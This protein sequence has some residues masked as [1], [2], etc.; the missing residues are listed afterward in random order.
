MN[1]FCYLL[2]H[3][4]S[5]K[6]YIG[7]TNNLERRLKMHNCQLVGGA[8]YTTTCVKC[9]GN[10]WNRV[11]YLS[12]FDKISSLQFE[13]RWKQISRQIKQNNPLER[14]VIALVKLLQLDRPTSNAKL[15]SEYNLDIKWEY[16]YLDTKIRFLE[17]R[18]PVLDKIKIRLK[19]KKL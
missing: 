8:K 14:R 19:L 13:W 4:S 1:W 6:T 9:T 2:E 5:K 12:G 18:K 17:Y 11:C 7:V 10:Y 15:Y 3:S 16:D